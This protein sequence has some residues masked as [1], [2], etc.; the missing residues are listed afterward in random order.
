MQKI[1]ETQ[2]KSDSTILYCA[3]IIQRLR[4]EWAIINFLT[5]ITDD[6]KFQPIR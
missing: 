6:I 2:L 3:F 1:V 4:I 5:C